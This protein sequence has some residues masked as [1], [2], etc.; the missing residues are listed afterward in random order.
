M[1]HAQIHR[2]RDLVAVH[3]PGNPTAYLTPKEAETLARMLTACAKDIKARRFTDHQFPT[4]TIAIA[5]R[6]TETGKPWLS[7]A[8]D[9]T[10]P[11]QEVTA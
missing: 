11:R 6:S 3:I 9:Y 1:P 10:H 5:D 4:A 8:R 2:F 7:S